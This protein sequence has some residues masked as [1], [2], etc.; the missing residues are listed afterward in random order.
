MHSHPSR[1]T[2]GRGHRDAADAVFTEVQRDFKGDADSRRAG[3]LI[4]FLNDFEGVVNVGQLSGGK[5]HIYHRSDDLNH[6]SYAH[7][8]PSLKMLNVK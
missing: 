7:L 4:L 3:G 5:L 6:F 1:E 8:S 2:V